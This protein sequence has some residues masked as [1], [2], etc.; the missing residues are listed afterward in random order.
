MH[1]RYSW[2]WLLSMTPSQ[3]LFRRN[4]P[5]H[6]EEEAGNTEL[7]VYPPSATAQIYAPGP[8][9]TAYQGIERGGGDGRGVW[10]GGG[11][12]GSRSL[13]Q[14]LLVSEKLIYSPPLAREHVYIF[15]LGIN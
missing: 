5:L 11:Q 6:T 13:Q 10:V 3:G 7:S 15:C 9:L 14:F 2:T 12:G 1:I 8:T 4:I